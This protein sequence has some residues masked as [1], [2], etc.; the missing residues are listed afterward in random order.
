MQFET[1]VVELLWTDKHRGYRI[2][3]EI[4]LVSEIEYELPLCMQ[5]Q[6]GAV[7][8]ILNRVM[9]EPIDFYAQYVDDCYTL[10]LRSTKKLTTHPCPVPREETTY[11]WFKRTSHILYKPPTEPQPSPVEGPL[12]RW[13]M[14]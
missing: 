10:D 1:P 14:K 3:S 9:I 8:P 2:R 5:R 13:L 4:D 11:D 7:P 12:D 6:L